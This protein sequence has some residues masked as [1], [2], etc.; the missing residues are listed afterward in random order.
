MKE[1]TE[2]VQKEVKEGKRACTIFFG[3]PRVSILL[4]FK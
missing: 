4:L 3:S 2:E 1:G